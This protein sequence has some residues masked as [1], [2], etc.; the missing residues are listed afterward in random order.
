MQ[1][2]FVLACAV[3]ALGQRAAAQM[4]DYMTPPFLPPAATVVTVIRAGR[5]V[6]VDKGVVLRDQM[7]VVRGDRIAAIE[8]A[9]GHVPPGARVIDLS[10]YTVTPGLIDCH[11]HLIGAETNADIL[12]PLERSAAQETLDGVVHARRTLL[13]R[14][15]TER[16]VGTLRAN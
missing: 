2:V 11:T 16:E 1:R 14:F 13:A 10:K 5:L 8:P 9:P 6:D 3:A 15:T 4:P 12:L 7:I